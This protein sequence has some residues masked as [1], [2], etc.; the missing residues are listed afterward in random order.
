MKHHLTGYMNVDPPFSIPRHRQG[1]QWRHERRR[2]RAAQAES[3]IDPAAGDERIREQIVLIG[4]E[5]TKSETQRPNVPP[6]L[7]FGIAP[8]IFD[9]QQPHDTESDPNQQLRCVETRDR[10]VEENQMSIIGDRRDAK[11]QRSESIQPPETRAVT[12]SYRNECDREQKPCRE[13][14][15]VKKRQ[16]SDRPTD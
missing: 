5:T 16:S 8:Q 7:R 11:C 13:S 6:S 1:E 15:T 14:D 12:G 9:R 2:D 4:E 10:R 3:G